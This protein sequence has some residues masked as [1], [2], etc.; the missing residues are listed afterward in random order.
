MVPGLFPFG[1]VGRRSGNATRP[2]S[3]HIPWLHGKNKGTGA[4]TTSP[5]DFAVRHQPSASSLRDEPTTTS[6]TAA[7][8]LPLPSLGMPFA[9]DAQVEGESGEA[10][11][12]SAAAPAVAPS[13]A[14]APLLA[15]APASAS[16]VAPAHLSGC[17]GGRGAEEAG[18]ADGRKKMPVTNA[19]MKAYVAM[20]AGLHGVAA[21]APEPLLGRMLDQELARGM[22]APQMVHNIKSA[23]ES[24]LP[25][26]PSRPE[27]YYYDRTGPDHHLSTPPG[28]DVE[29]IAALNRKRGDGWASAN[30]KAD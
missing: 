7:Y 30:A 21:D 9:W 16:P 2:S 20:R 10:A 6:P 29:G 17:S 4:A 28:Y 19:M 24:D 11:A 15:L 22:E 14:P 27:V 1:S 26:G 3:L 25:D 13:P 12:F 18:P 8:L 23:L 5:A